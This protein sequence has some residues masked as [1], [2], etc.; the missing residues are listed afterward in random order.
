MAHSVATVPISEID[1][2][3]ETLTRLVED[4]GATTVLRAMSR[5]LR[6]ARKVRRTEGELDAARSLRRASL[7]CLEQSLLLAE[8]GV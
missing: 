2:P 3:L 5:A 1:E 8:E 4:Y 6:D 7:A